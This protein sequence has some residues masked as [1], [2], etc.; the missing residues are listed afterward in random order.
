LVVITLA[1]WIAQEGFGLAP[2]L[3]R[4]WVIP[5]AAQL[6]LLFVLRA[7][8]SP[9]LAPASSR[10]EPFGRFVAIFR[11]IEEQRFAAPRLARIHGSIRDASRELSRLQTILGFAE[12]RYAGI[13]AVFLNVFLLWDVFCAAALLG[14]RARA[15][16]SVRGWLSAMAELEALAS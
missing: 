2:S 13:V 15:G 8:L 16:R 6:V 5:F 12:V 3:R 11:L 14:W 9:V 10:E 1:A 4:A 7:K